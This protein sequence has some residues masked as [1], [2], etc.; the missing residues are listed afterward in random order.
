MPCALIYGVIM[1]HEA[2][3]Q[4]IASARG[5][6]RSPSPVALAQGALIR[7]RLGPLLNPGGVVIPP[8]PAKRRREHLGIGALG[9]LQRLLQNGLSLL[10]GA[11][12][13]GLSAAHTQNSHPL[14]IPHVVGD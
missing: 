10:L 13:V 8:F 7:R 12:D 5:G 9:A 1:P 11:G 6:L 14:D 4:S 3:S 2:A